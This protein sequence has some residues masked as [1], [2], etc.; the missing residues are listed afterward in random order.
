MT[1]NE[2]V[3][4][5]DEIRIL[6]KIKW[7]DIGAIYLNKKAGAW[8]T[9]RVWKEFQVVDPKPGPGASIYGFGPKIQ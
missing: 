7:M 8:R 6:K 2:L 5:L 1:L 9:C 4:G 3:V